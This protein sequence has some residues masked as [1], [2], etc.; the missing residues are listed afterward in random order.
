[1]KAKKQRY[2][3]QV[4]SMFIMGMAMLL[5]SC[6][7]D[8][9]TLPVEVPVYFV[10]E[11]A[12]VNNPGKGNPFLGMD[13]VRIS[14]MDIRFDGDREQGED[15]FFTAGFKNSR[16]YML[17]AVLDTPAVRFDIPQ[18][19]Y[20]HMIFTLEVGAGSRHGISFRG[21]FIETGR[22]RKEIPLHLD[23]FLE[24][25]LIQILVK[26]DDNGQEITIQ[27]GAENEIDIVLDLEYLFRLIL[28]NR[29]QQAKRE[30]HGGQEIIHIAPGKNE[31]IYYDLANRLS[32]SF[33]AV[34]K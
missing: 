27:K 25:E 14:I 34:Y 22:E 1:M 24:P 32:K 10:M 4:L 11:N 18:G 19:E 31:D 6:G 28:G 20:K 9:L 30:Q 13:S 33:R 8:P 21:K 3:F 26:K 5:Y 15:I 23:F 29:L 12:P 16:A 7:K 17:N 2:W